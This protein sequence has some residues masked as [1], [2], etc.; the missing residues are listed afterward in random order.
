MKRL[1]TLLF[2]VLFIAP[3]FARDF[4]YKHKGR[5]LTYTVLD[6]EA[7]T[8]CTK[9]GKLG[10]SN[11]GIYVY[12]VLT[13]PEIAKDGNTEYRVTAI[14]EHSFSYCRDLISV[15]LP[16]SLQ[17]IGKEA[18]T[19]T[20]LESVT[21]PDGVVS[22]GD[23]AFAS[24]RNL[25]SVTMGNSVIGIGENA[26]YN[27]SELTDITISD[28]VETLGN[29]V[30]YKCTSLASANLGSRVRT[31][32]SECFAGCLMLRS[33]DMGISVE[34]IGK[35]AFAQ[36]QL[37]KSITIP[38]KVLNIGM[39]TFKDCLTLKTAVIGNS[40]RSIGDR[41]FYNCQSLKSVT[42]GSSVAQIGY[43]VFENCKTLGDVILPPALMSIAEKAFYD[44][45][46]IQ[47][48]YL[49]PNVW[50]IEKSAFYGS[51]SKTVYITAQTPP[52]LGKYSLSGKT[53]Y[54]QGD[55]AY[56]VYKTSVTNW[57]KYAEYNR[58]IEP[59]DMEINAEEI[60]GNAGDT[61]QL[62][63]KLIPEDVTLPYIFWRSTN[64]DVAT[65]DHNGLVTIHRGPADV[66]ADES[67]EY[68]PFSCNIIA[69]SL[70]YEG[71]A[72][73]VLV[74]GGESAIGS[75]TDDSENSNDNNANGEI[76]FNAPA[77]VYNLQG[78]MIGRN[79]C[80]LPAGIYII[81]QGKNVKKLR[82]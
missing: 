34:T 78:T 72:P 5:T 52:T 63:A 80:N 42:F 3:G 19:G 41:A 26:F 36:C 68:K 11:P 25:T 12:G 15:T 62:T 58:M 9:A 31:I 69:E 20:G 14:G 54:V 2:S 45:D 8:C 33:V 76:D 28:S 43:N 61:F 64:P 17:D 75:I 4:E 73:E 71:P 22:I 74:N 55:K 82:L 60:E 49:G 40:V 70:Y 18:F 30:F 51:Y 46:Q 27:C 77:E 81:R 79:A 13:I 24:C 44:A 32:G 7:K 1:M 53:L 37:L 21:I 57:G 10:S 56:S 47:S 29:K 50:H 38:D 16:N 48:V 39:E 6:E 65:V 66:A 67:G 59:T 23:D 35:M